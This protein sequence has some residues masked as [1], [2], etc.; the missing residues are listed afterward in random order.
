MRRQLLALAALL[1]PQPGAR[2]AAQA[3]PAPAPAAPPRTAPAPARAAFPPPTSRACAPPAARVTIVRDRWGVAHVYGRSDADAV[4]GMIYAQAEDDFARVERNYIVAMGR[5]AE[6][7]GAAEL[8]R[9]LRMRLFVDPVELRAQYAASPAWLR[10]LMDAWAD[11][12]NYYLATH[13]AARP[14]LLTRFEPWMALAFTEGSIGGEIEDI[15]L[16]GLAQ[17]YGARGGAGA[18][19]GATN[20]TGGGA[21][22]APG[23]PAPGAPAPAAAAPAPRDPALQ[24][25]AGS[26]GFA[27]APARSASGHA[28]L[29]INPH[30]SFYFRPEIH[31]ASGEGLN[32]Y[33]AV[34]WGQFFVYQGFNDRAGW[35]HTSGGG[36][37]ID[38]YLER[39]E[40][41]GGRFA[42]RYGAGERPV[43]A[44]AIALPYRLP[45]GGT[46]RRTVTA[47]FTHH[48]P[49]VRAEGGRWVACGSC[50][51]PVQALQQSSCHEGALV[52]EFARVMALRTNS[53]NNT[54]YADAD[55][56][57]RVLARQLRPVRDTSFDWTKPSTAATRAPSGE[58]LH[59]VRSR[60]R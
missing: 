10:R 36:D 41:R 12:L 37:V 9:D 22:P 24:E 14:K 23:A 19:H 26:N 56:H 38:E 35:M 39:V 15:A 49:V 7:E 21:A 33:G 32:A 20:G 48:G 44:K 34:T 59:R 54:V 6:V 40:G 51:S 30:T 57:H 29:L 50:R 31:V 18:T 58:G 53:S 52:R 42:Y 17:F 13:P 2:L 46:G 3:A 60:S 16:A 43:R 27:I 45:G 25:P 4:F 5:L 55:G 8:W 28:L 1:A 11:G 47:Y